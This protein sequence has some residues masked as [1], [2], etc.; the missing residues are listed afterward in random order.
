MTIRLTIAIPTYSRYEPL[1]LTIQQVL[2]VLHEDEELLVVDQNSGMPVHIEQSLV[3][4]EQ[5][6]RLR[7][8]ILD[9]PSL[10]TARNTALRYASGHIVLFLDD[11][12]FVPRETIDFHVQAYQSGMYSAVTGQVFQCASEM[13]LPPDWNSLKNNSEKHHNSDIAQVTDTVIGCNHSVR[14]AAVLRIGG[15]DEAF[16]A[17]AHGEDFD[18]GHRI[19]LA[20]YKVY[21]EPRAWLIHFKA[22]TGGCRVVEPWSSMEWSN[23]A[24]LFLYAF[25]HGK[26]K[27]NFWMYIYLA[28]RAGPLR[29]AVLRRPWLW[30]WAWGHCL[31]GAWYG[32]RHRRFSSVYFV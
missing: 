6:G 29:R 22:P 3:A 17:A 2:T 4:W 28:M 20:E 5:G 19:S 7:R 18:I 8:I 15:Y 13:R 23:S 16:V 30:L 21:Y 9:H 10:T 12:V 1:V 31:K 26:R 25:R 14:K 24:N 32:Y 27:C 11:D